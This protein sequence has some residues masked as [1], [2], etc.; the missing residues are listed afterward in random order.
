M[1]S[2]L[3]EVCLS[4]RVVERTLQRISSLDSQEQIVGHGKWKLAVKKIGE[5][6]PPPAFLKIWI[7]CIAAL[8][9]NFSGLT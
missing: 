3:R 8:A 6:K 9:E 7:E 5:E 4:E 1:R 2:R